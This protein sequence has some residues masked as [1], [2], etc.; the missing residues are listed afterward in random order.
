M[1]VLPNRVVV[2]LTP[3]FAAAAGWLLTEVTKLTG[4][5][6]N[7]AE[8]TAAFVTGALAATSAAVTWLIGW[9]KHEAN[10]LGLHVV[11]VVATKPP[12]E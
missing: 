7:N 8:L 9:M 11:P 4:L 10:E 1:K 6:L 12:V 3:V 5:H 2:V